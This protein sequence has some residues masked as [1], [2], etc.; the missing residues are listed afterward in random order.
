MRKLLL[1]GM[2]VSG[3]ANAGTVVH[4]CNSYTLYQGTGN[5]NY[6]KVDDNTQSSHIIQITVTDPVIEVL[7]KDTEMPV[8]QFWKDYNVY[9]NDTGTLEQGGTTFTMKTAVPKG[10]I[11]I[12]VKIVYHCN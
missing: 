12:P 8:V 5:G 11:Y 6:Q 9:R 2:L 3:L 4:T 10:G 7:V 1:L